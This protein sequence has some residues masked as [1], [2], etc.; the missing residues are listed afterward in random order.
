MVVADVAASLAFYRRLGLDVP[1]D[2]DTAPHVET[3]LPGGLRLAWDS[4]ETIRSF[5]PSYARERAGNRIG[6]AFRCACPADVD[7]LFAELTADGVRAHLAPFDAPWGQRYATVLD[8]DGGSVD[9][10]ADLG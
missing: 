5:D 9:L 2:A 8:P 4:E 3:T 1:A 6:L 7:A 10:F